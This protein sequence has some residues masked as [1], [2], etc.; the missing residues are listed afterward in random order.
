M[1]VSGNKFFWNSRRFKQITE[2]RNLA[3]YLFALI[4][5]AITWS[6]VKTMQNN[7]DLQKQISTLKQQNNVL[8]LQNEDSALQNQFY[9]TNQ[10]LDL[11][12]RQNL[13]LAAPGEK[14]LLVP[15][16]TAQ[17]YVDQA[18][19]STTQPTNTAVK[20]TSKYVKNLEDWR[21]FLLGRKLFTD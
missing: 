15:N 6:G 14:V 19:V 2:V 13:G 20:S 3:L 7:Y 12:A 8:Q 16:A 4:V 1:V 5:L 11:S 17:K 9:Q 21:D 18:I 10:Y